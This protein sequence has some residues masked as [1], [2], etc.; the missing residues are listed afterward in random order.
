MPSSS[1]SQNSLE[2]HII[3]TGGYIERGG[4]GRGGRDSTEQREETAVKKDLESQ[5]QEDANR[6]RD[7]AWYGREGEERAALSKC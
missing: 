7:E 3:D 6:E 5:V 1:L 4:R 2:V